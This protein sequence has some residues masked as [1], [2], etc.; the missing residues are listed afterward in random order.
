[1]KTGPSWHDKQL[2]SQPT[3]VSQVPLHN[4]F[5][6]LELEGEMSEDVMGGPS[7]R[8][9]RVRRWTQHLK[10]AST[11]KDRR[12][13]VVGNSL[14]GGME[15]SICRSDSTCREVCLPKAW[16]RNISR[17]LPSLIHHSDYYPSLIVQTSSVEVTE[18]SL[19][20]IKKDFRGLGQLVDG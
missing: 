8:L 6:V 11:R 12:V 9:P 19:R 7:M 13:I 5:E 16:M 1:V 14:L 20:I 3:L 17:K 2:P 4:R 15:G 18:V 10:I